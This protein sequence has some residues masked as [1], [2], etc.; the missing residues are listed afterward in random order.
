M[1][2][3]T[4]ACCW[5]F[6]HSEKVKAKKTKPKQKQFSAYI[7]LWHCVGFL[8]WFSFSFSPPLSICSRPL[9]QINVDK[10][11]KCLHVLFK[12]ALCVAALNVATL[13]SNQS[14]SLSS[15]DSKQPDC[16]GGEWQPL[17]G[18][19]CLKC[20][21]WRLFYILWKLFRQQ[22]FLESLSFLLFCVIKQFPSMP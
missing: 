12:K 4:L 21:S 3:L 10:S 6:R 1:T 14:L 22:P 9:L 16:D 17:S 11:H 19:S 15:N 5:D 20:V 13:L 7:S 2:Q 18:S 8:R